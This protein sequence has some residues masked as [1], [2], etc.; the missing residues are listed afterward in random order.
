MTE[1]CKTVTRHKTESGIPESELDALLD[2]LSDEGWDVE[3][4]CEV[5]LATV[6]RTAGQEPTY[7]L[8]ATREVCACKPKRS[9]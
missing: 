6:D 8:A 9:K 7:S 1:P 5:E 2:Q 4:E 3:F